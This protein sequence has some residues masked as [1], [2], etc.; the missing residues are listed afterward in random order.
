[1]K[2]V[3][4]LVLMCLASNF[5]SRAALQ[6]ENLALRH[7]LCVF[8]RSV[9]RA[10][11]RPADRILWSFLAGVWSGWRDALIFVKPETVI[12]WQRKRFKKHWTQLTRRGE[13][14]RPAI[15]DEVQELIRTMS[16]MNP[17]WGVPRIVGELAKLGINVA[18]ST[19][20][21]YMVRVCK[22]PSQ[23]WRVF[24]R[25]HTKDIVSI[26]FLVVPT[27]RFKMLYV[28]VFL[29]IDR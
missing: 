6:A 17:T 13:P 23:T 5:K 28:L 29:S 19:V 16:R 12:R 10:K 27:I 11:V 26:Y 22:P 3:I 2:E 24:L 20:E 8:Q 7:E 14:G 15:S 4:L 1:M 9:K 21:R 18:K 25:N